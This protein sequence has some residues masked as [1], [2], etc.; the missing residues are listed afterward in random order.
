MTA[1]M[2][3]DPD[4]IRQQIPHYLTADPAK[5]ELLSNLKAL[6]GGATSGYF[7]TN[8]AS[9]SATEILQGDGWRGFEIISFQS[10]ERK[11]S[12]GIVLSNSCDIATDNE[13]S[14]PPNVAFAPITRLSNIRERFEKH[15]LKEQQIDSKIQAI[16]AQTITSIFYL[17]AESPLEEEHVA[18]LDD[19]HSMPVQ[20]FKKNANKLFTLSNSG[21]YL[22]IFKLSIHFCRFHEGIDRRT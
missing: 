13:R 11:S 7:L 20:N 5:K 16:R 17:P 12:R 19:L 4:F 21:F 6:I 18:L 9:S 10:G 22:F 8:S 15:G 1:K 2:T 14:W 3:F